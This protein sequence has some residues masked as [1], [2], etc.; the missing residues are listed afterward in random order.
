MEE[1]T[2]FFDMEFLAKGRRRRVGGDPG[3]NDG[4]DGMA[5]Q[6]LEAPVDHV[7]SAGRGSVVRSQRTRISSWLNV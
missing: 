7:G 6:V 2:P 1:Q 3:M 4:I 5:Q